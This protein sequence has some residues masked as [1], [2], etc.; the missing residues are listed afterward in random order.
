MPSEEEVGTDKTLEV[1]LHD[2]L[3]GHLYQLHSG[4]ISYQYVLEAS[5]ALSLSL[6]VQYEAYS[7]GQCFAYFDGL[8]PE[9]E[10]QRE[11][12]AKKFSINKKNSFRLLQAIGADCAGAVSFHEP[13]SKTGSYRKEEAKEVSEKELEDLIHELPQNPFFISKKNQLRLSL[14]GAQPKAAVIYRDGKIF[15]PL[16]ETPTTHIIK[17][18]VE[19]LNQTTSNEFFSLIV[20]KSLGLVVPAIELKTAGQTPYLL[21]ERYDR[22]SKD[23]KIKRI[24]QE[25]FC[26]ALN[27]TSSDKYESDG[28]P[29]VSDCMKLLLET[30][31]PVNSRNQFMRML[32][33]NYLFGNMDA[34]G[35]NYSLLH[36][37]DGII[38]IA[39]MYDPA[40]TLIYA[41]LE[42]KMAMKIG[43]KY[44]PLQIFPR[45]WKRTCELSGYS[46]PGLLRVLGKYCISIPT[47]AEKY[48]DNLKS[49]G[50]EVGFLDSVYEVVKDICHL[51]LD[52]LS[53]EERLK[54]ERRK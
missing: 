33:F 31:S 12:I 37:D 5:R 45:H 21:I 41:E 19:G 3:V 27:I 54:A 49:K 53:A 50:I 26:Q 47:N 9:S 48:I 40:C 11:A 36:K 30:S 18:A 2:E 4:D 44:D 1:W 39:P 34:H 10:F 28:G 46:Y 20:A 7:Q 42:R 52:R 25:D 15:L 24:H 13:R 35:K 38:E 14:A 23:G 22:I 8:L 16:N 6:P 32:V 51:S 17:P 29:S 43:G